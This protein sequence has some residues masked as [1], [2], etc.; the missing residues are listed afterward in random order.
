MARH[1]SLLAAVT[2]ALLAGAASAAPETPVASAF[3]A[4]LPLP[5]PGVGMLILA[6]LAFGFWRGRDPVTRSRR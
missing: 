1:G 4:M 6:A 3:H 2:C 5:E